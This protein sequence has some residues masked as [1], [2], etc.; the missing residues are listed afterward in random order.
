MQ[1][2]ALTC[3]R[4][5]PR[6]TQRFKNSRFS[7]APSGHLVLHPWG[8]HRLNP[9][10]YLV[11]AAIGH[12]TFPRVRQSLQ[13]TL[14]GNLVPTLNVLHLTQIQT[15]IHKARAQASLPWENPEPV[16]LPPEIAL[17]H[18]GLGLGGADPSSRKLTSLVLKSLVQI[19]FHI[20][21]TLQTSVVEKTIHWIHVSSN[22]IADPAQPHGKRKAL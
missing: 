10:V 22:I 9:V 14:C 2:I 19:K 8:Q 11:V 4:H 13:L 1:P 15:H 20:E 5:S 21:W 3:A 6:T 12:F 18:K 17:H 16:A 7:R